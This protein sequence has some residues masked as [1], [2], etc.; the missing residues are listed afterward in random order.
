M[1][2]L[3]VRYLGITIRNLVALGVSTSKAR[4]MVFSDMAYKASVFFTAIFIL[5]VIRTNIIQIGRNGIL[6]IQYYQK[7]GHVFEKKI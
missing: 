3:T 1:E 5:S 4:L 6:I 7:F 2:K